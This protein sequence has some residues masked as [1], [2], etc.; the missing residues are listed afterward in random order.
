MQVGNTSLR[1]APRRRSF[2]THY[3]LIA[4]RPPHRSQILHSKR[5]DSGLLPNLSSRNVESLGR[6]PDF[7]TSNIETLGCSPISAR[8]KSRARDASWI[9]HAKRR[10]SWAGSRSLHLTSR[11]SGMLTRDSARQTSKLRGPYR[12]LHLKSSR[13]RDAS[14]TLYSRRRDSGL[15]SRSLHVKSREFAA[16]SRLDA[17]KK[18]GECLSRFFSTRVFDKKHPSTK[19]YF[20]CNVLAFFRKPQVHVWKTHHVRTSGFFQLHHLYVGRN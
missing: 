12:S 4:Q 16:R 18:Y 7:C 17:P 11:T 10:E 5:R 14:Q 15:L 13:V 2:S 1:G 19:I 8:E 20:V 6:V 3:H 9:L